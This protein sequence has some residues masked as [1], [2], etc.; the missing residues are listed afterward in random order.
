[1]NLHTKSDRCKLLHQFTIMP[2]DNVLDHFDWEDDSGRKTKANAD[3]YVGFDPNVETLRI[4][5]YAFSWQA[6]LAALQLRNNK[7]PCFIT[8]ALTSNILHLEW[9]Q[10]DLYVRK[11]DAD[12]ALA[13]LEENTEEES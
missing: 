3:F 11:A 12:F 10:V 6:E 1:M 2:I 7:I 4:S 9:T 5:R 8:N 13:I